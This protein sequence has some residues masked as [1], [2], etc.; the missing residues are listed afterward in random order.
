MGYNEG[1]GRGDEGKGKGEGRED[2][3]EQ[4]KGRRGDYTLEAKLEIW[5]S[6]VASRC[7]IAL[8]PPPKSYDLSLSVCS[9]G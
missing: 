2:G 4:G 5:S 3:K 7:G 1:I 9:S 6:A 8:I